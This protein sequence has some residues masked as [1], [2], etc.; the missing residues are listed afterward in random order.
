MA[1]VSDTVLWD[2]GVLTLHGLTEPILLGNIISVS[3]DKSAW[4]IRTTTGLVLIPAR[5]VV[6]LDLQNAKP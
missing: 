1:K 4:W 6:S 2:K 5:E 3:P